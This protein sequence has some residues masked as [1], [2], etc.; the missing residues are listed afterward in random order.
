MAAIWRER[1]EINK[2]WL[3]RWLEIECVKSWIR[4]VAIVGEKAELKKRLP[5]ELFRERA[6]PREPFQKKKNVQKHFHK[7]I[8]SSFTGLLDSIRRWCLCWWEFLNLMQLFS[9]SGYCVRLGARLVW[10]EC[11]AS[12]RLLWGECEETLCWRGSEMHGSAGFELF[13]RSTSDYKALLAEFEAQIERL[14]EQCENTG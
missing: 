8:S 11:E 14:I 13:V 4:I 6:A 1:K 5:R 3:E 9:G 7:R 12:V 10:G 2:R